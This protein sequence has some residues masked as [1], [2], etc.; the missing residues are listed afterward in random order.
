[1]DR[2][3]YYAASAFG[4]E[5]MRVDIIGAQDSFEGLMSFRCKLG[6]ASGQ[7]MGV[8]PVQ[9]GAFDVE[10]EI[11]EE[12]SE[13]RFSTSGVAEISGEGEVEGQVLIAGEVVNIG[14]G[15][16][17]VVDIRVCS[18]IMMIEILNRK[19]ELT[20]GD[21]ISFRSSNIQLYPYDL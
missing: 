3:Q 1:M 13:W 9:V 19:F 5:V 6:V 18:D 14:E 12:I 15:S 16:D 8:K 21:F 10:I 11:P 20:K 17:P 2:W 7:W 4:G